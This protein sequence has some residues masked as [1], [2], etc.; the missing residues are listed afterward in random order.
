[1]TLEH[2][3]KTSMSKGIKTVRVLRQQH[4][5]ETLCFYNDNVIVNTVKNLVCD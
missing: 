1:M 4:G 2:C 5:I 3:Y